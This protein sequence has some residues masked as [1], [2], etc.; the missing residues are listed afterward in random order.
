MP[1]LDTVVLFAAADPEDAFH[2]KALEHLAK[3][4]TRYVLATSALIEFDIVLKSRGFDYNERMEK[5]ALLIRDFPAA[6]EAVHRIT[7]ATLYLAA[8]HERD[9]DLDYFDACVAAEAWE[10]DGIVVSTDESFDV[11]PDL[12]RMW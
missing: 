11:I 4:G 12:K 7:P 10:H 9:F 5:F 2:E 3:L 6:A 1:V 8:L